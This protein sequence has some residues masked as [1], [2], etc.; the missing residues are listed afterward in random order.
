MSTQNNSG[1][2]TFT[3]TA[4]AIEANTRVVLGAAGTISAA[5]ETDYGIGWTT[6]YIVASGSGTVKL[7]GSQG[8]QLAQVASVVTVG[9]MLY[10]AASGEVD[11]TGTYRIKYRAGGTS[12]AQGDVIEIIP[13]EDFAVSTIAFSADEVG[14]LAA[15]GNSAATGG[16]IVKRITFVTLADDSTGVT[17]PAVTAGLLYVIHNTV[18]NKHLHIYPATGD[19]IIPLGAD[20]VQTLAASS[21][22]MF[23]GLGTTNWACI[24]GTAPA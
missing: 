21:T 22:A 10:S 16:V 5:G 12:T 7:V 23:I 3:A 8:T 20:T 18:A 17:L 1:Y 4:A 6:E 19:N 14:T 11:N 2:M 9:D 15:A 24:Q 13:T